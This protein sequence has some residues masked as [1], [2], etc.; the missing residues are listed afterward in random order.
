LPKISE[1]DFACDEML[2]KFRSHVQQCTECQQK[3]D[4][5]PNRIIEERPIVGTVL[6]ALGMDLKILM[7]NP[8]SKFIIGDTIDAK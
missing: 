6:S 1:K 4:N 2:E 7:K 5:L 8:L 3:I